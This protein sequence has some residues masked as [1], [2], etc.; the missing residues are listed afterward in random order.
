MSRSFKSHCVSYLLSPSTNSTKRQSVPRYGLAHKEEAAEQGYSG[1][2]WTYR[3]SKELTF[4]S[5]NH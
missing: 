4:V 1:L 2:Q 5:A 3:A